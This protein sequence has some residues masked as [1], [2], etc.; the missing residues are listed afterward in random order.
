MILRGGL[1]SDGD[2]SPLRI[3]IQLVQ[4]EIIRMEN[5]ELVRFDGCRREI[6]KIRGDQDFYIGTHRSGQHM[7][8]LVVAHHGRFKVTMSCNGGIRERTPHLI[9]PVPHLTIVQTRHVD[10]VP[11]QLDQ[12]VL[13]P[14]GPKRLRLGKSQQGVAQMQRLACAA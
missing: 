1:S 2:E 3:K 12:D 4:Q 6:T 8:V 5:R 11:L 13:R 14:Q 10:Q 7:S 9:D